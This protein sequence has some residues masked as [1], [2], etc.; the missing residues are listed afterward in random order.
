MKIGGDYVILNG[1]KWDISNFKDGDIA[2]FTHKNA[3]HQAY[4]RNK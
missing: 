1:L 2:H 4:I 3:M